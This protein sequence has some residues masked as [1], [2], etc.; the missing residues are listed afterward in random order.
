MNFIGKRYYGKVFGALLGWM[1]VRHPIGLLIGALI[2]HALDAGWLRRKNKRGPLEQAYYVLQVSS[3]ATD[4]EIDTAYRRL[5]A[6]FHPDRVADK[7]E[8]VREFAERHA[9]DI[10][11]AYDTVMKARRKNG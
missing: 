4:E 5:M 8:A 10:N 1:L 9:R 11:A 2:G 3:D 6:K 7:P